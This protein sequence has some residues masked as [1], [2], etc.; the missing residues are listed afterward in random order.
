MG[1]INVLLSFKNFSFRVPTGFCCDIDSEQNVLL[2]IDKMQ[3]KTLVF[4]NLS[5]NII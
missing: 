1:D 3:R 5:S 4:E 2:V